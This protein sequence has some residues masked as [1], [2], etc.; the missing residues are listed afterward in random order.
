[1]ILEKEE[2]DFIYERLNRKE[3]IDLLSA[4][5]GLPKDMLFNILGRKIVRKV[6]RDYY[7]VKPKAKYYLKEWRNGSSILSMAESTNFSPVILAKFI[8]SEMGFNKKEINR[9]LLNPD[10]IEEKRLR[11]EIREVI[12]EDFVYSP[13]AAEIQNKNGKAAENEIKKWL[14][15]QGIPF[16]T[17]YENKEINRKNGISGKT[18]DFLLKKTLKIGNRSYHWIESKASFGDEQ[19]MKRDFKKQFKPYLE[20]FGSGIVVYWYGFIKGAKLD[21]KIK[22]VEKEF[23]Y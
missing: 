23:F 3:D 13:W 1:M 9:M 14:E 10:S 12:K 20:L 5:M 15:K 8:L 17:E 6:M 4:R 22:I 21:P 19:E 11:K 2:F 16:V 7:K 18:P